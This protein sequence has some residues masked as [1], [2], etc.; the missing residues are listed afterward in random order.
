MNKKE[1]LYL[2]V[3]FELIGFLLLWIAPSCYTLVY[4]EDLFL[5]CSN[6]RMIY[7]MWGLI[8]VLVGFLFLILEGKANE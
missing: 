1:W 4:L 7:G 3:G 5:V 6:K 2:F 8:F